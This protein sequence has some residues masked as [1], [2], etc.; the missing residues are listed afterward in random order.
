[1]GIAR[2][3]DLTVGTPVKVLSLYAIPMLISMFF[4][5]AYNGNII[6]G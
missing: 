2:T 6:I 4:Q 3:H 1:M 5:Q